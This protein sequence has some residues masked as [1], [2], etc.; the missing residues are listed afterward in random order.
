MNSLPM[1]QS[2]PPFSLQLQLQM[3]R[4]KSLTTYLLDYMR[5]F[6]TDSTNEPPPH[7]SSPGV[8]QYIPIIIA[9]TALN[10]S[11]LPA[12]TCEPRIH[13]T[14][15]IF[16]TLPP[17]EF[18]YVDYSSSYFRPYHPYLPCK[19][20]SRT[21]HPTLSSLDHPPCQRE[22]RHLCNPPLP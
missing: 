14:C 3:Q 8:Y 19:P 2:K 7:I 9:P 21:R 10:L 12:S 1:D 22:A 20:R 11:W 15:Y 6:H 4:I 18:P 5:D 17:H 13:L 16:P